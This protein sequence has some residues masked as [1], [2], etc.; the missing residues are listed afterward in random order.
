M[1]ELIQAT[2]AATMP[3]T[4]DTA[5]EEYNQKAQELEG[6]LDRL[7]GRKSKEEALADWFENTVDLDVTV[8]P[9]A[10]KGMIIIFI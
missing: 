10:K 8:K 6:R 2:E 7:E 9:M 5:Q 4:D 1:T 3:T